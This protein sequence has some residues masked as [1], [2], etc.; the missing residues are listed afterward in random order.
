ME[1]FGKEYENVEE[2]SR[3]MLVWLEN[4][5]EYFESVNDS[6]NSIA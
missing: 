6:F 4:H 3:R 2:K 1:R 5:G